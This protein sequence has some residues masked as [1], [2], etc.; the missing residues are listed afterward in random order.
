[1]MAVIQGMSTLA[2]DGASRAKL[3]RV[4]TSAMHAWPDPPPPRVAAASRRTRAPRSIRRSK[5]EVE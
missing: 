1:V 3:L 5:R 4:A 2:R